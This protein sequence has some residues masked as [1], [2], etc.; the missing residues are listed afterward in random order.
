MVL[1]A[2][3][4]TTS[5]PRSKQDLRRRAI[6]APG[7]KQPPKPTVVC[8]AAALTTQAPSRGL[9]HDATVAGRVD[10]GAANGLT[11]GSAMFCTVAASWLCL[12]LLFTS[13]L[14]KKAR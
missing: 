3:P 14:P 4:A 8:Q 5:Q 2:A 9:T 13:N 10:R 1:Q 7:G 12:Q 11:R 6:C